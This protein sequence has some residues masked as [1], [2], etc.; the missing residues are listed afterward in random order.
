L[1]PFV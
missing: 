1:M